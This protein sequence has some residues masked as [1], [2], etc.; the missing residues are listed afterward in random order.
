M[1]RRRIVLTLSALVVGLAATDQILG[2]LLIRDGM[3]KGRYLPPFGTMEREDVREGVLQ[4][5]RIL[6]S[7]GSPARIRNVWDRE[8]GWTNRP[9]RGLDR[10]EAVTINALGARGSTEYGPE[11][12]EGVLRLIC[13]GDSF[14]YCT[15]V[16]DRDAWPS[17]L[18]TDYEGVE[19]VN[20]GVGAYGLDQAL[21]R[22]RRKGLLG[23]DVCVA[24][25]ALRGIDRNVAR[26]FSF[27]QPSET[28]VKAKPRFVPGHGGLE[29][30]PLPYETQLEFLRAVWD[31]RVRSDLAPMDHW[32][33]DDPLI[34][35]SAF[36]RAWAGNEAYRRRTL[37]A[38]W[39][40][41]CDAAQ[42]TVEILDAFRREALEGGASRFVAVVFPLEQDLVLMQRR[43]KRRSLPW[44]PM[45]AQLAERGIE[46][47]ELQR[48]LLQDHRREP[49]YEHTHFSEH[50]NRVI[51]DQVAAWLEGAGYE[52][53][54]R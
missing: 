23:A 11:P 46:T 20:M 7:G 31:G 8:L 35:G 22:F 6:E 14:V 26:Y 51:A 21:L 47:I 43:R 25:F 28:L 54:P 1:R 17:L 42:V 16:G 44:D 4:K 39:G 29:L 52:L 2:R 27:C 12:S 41:D 36:C 34:P 49:L 33:G 30:V 19:A 38:V 45:L 3:Y 53:R 24:G 40:P 48:I 18:E 9:G 10:E 5:I 15:E 50:G 13:Y 32:A 37:K